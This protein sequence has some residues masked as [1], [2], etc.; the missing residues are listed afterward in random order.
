M[1]KKD[2][3]KLADAYA[4]NTKLQIRIMNLR[5]QVKDRDK[6]IVG[7]QNAA[8]ELMIDRKD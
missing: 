2:E 5:Q 6:T 3:Q 8:R 4:E 7:L 1:S